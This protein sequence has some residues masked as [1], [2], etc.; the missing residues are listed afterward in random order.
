[1]GAVVAG[2]R[3][4]RKLQPGPGLAA[5]CPHSIELGILRGSLWANPFNRK[6]SLTMRLA[7]R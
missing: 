4:Q 6:A 5:D 7:T 3:R 2:K 1:M